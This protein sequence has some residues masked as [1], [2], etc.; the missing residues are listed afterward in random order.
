[1]TALLTLVILTVVLVAAFHEDVIDTIADV[2]DYWVRRMGSP[3]GDST[4]PPEED[5]RS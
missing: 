1:M 5:S 2:R 3:P 4:T